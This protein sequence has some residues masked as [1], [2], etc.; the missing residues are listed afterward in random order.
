MAGRTTDLSIQRLVQSVC[1]AVAVIPVK[2]SEHGKVPI[3][4]AGIGYVSDETVHVVD[5]GLGQPRRIQIS[6]DGGSQNEVTIVEVVVVVKRVPE[7][8]AIIT[9]LVGC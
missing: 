4:R 1:P 2:V 8:G 9:R 7:V 6:N 5:V 3:L